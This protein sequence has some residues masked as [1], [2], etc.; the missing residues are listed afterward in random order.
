VYY[1]REILRDFG[2]AQTAPTYIYED[3]LACVPM[4]RT[5]KG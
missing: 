3:D 5:I 1:M 2:H 4:L